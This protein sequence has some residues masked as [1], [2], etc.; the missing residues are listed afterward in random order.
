MFRHLR[1]QILISILITFLIPFGVHAQEPTP[2]TTDTITTPFSPVTDSSLL[3]EEISLLRQQ[4]EELRQQHTSITAQVTAFQEYRGDLIEIIA[5]AMTIVVAFAF[6]NFAYNLY[7]SNHQEKNVRA[8]LGEELTKQVNVVADKN[9]TQIKELFE[10]RATELRNLVT[11]GTSQ[12]EK[13]REV[14]QQQLTTFVD[15]TL[16]RISHGIATTLLDVGGEENE[17]LTPAEATVYLR[18]HLQQLK[19]LSDFLHGSKSFTDQKEINKLIET[20]LPPL[21]E[22]METMKAQGFTLTREQY[23]MHIDLLEKIFEKNRDISIESQT[24]RK[25]LMALRSVS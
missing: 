23:E 9:E 21:L 3:I 10:G 19:R 6:G 2:T 16:Q 11:N 15:D 4:N 18:I 8:A 20:E 25:S 1:W 24:Y 5:T 17:K 13:S 7:Q 12:I 14:A 22:R